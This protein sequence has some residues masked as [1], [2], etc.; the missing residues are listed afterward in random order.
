M[1][2]F[3]VTWMISCA[4]HAGELGFVL[5]QRQRAAGDVDVAARRRQRVDAVGVEDDELP[6]QIRP[7]CCACASAA[8]TSVDVLVNRRDPARRRSA[9]RIFSLTACADLLLFFVG[10]LEIV[11][12]LRLLEHRADLPGPPDPR[13]GPAPTAAAGPATASRRRTL[14]SC[15]CHDSCFRGVAVFSLS[16]SERL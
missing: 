1:V 2:C 4:E 16:A 6:R 8:P 15:A 14:P 3:S 11:D 5:H 10:D 9:A 13:A 7:R 12:L